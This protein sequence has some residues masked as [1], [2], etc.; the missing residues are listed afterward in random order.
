MGRHVL[1]LEGKYLGRPMQT[2]SDWRFSSL[3]RREGLYMRRW[4]PKRN[5]PD[6]WGIIVLT[7]RF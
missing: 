6:S 3:F 7:A 2:H 5:R 1:T 4:K